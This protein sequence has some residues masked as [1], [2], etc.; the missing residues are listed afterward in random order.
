M[1]KL[2]ANFENQIQLRLFSNGLIVARDEMYQFQ[3]Y[4]PT[5]PALTW[6]E[7]RDGT[8]FS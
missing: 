8:G 6:K 4:V 2:A 1:L 3:K 7:G 5:V